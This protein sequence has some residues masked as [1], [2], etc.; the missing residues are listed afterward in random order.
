MLV[1]CGWVDPAT[2]YLSGLTFFYYPGF[3][4]FDQDRKVE[5]ESEYDDDG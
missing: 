1:A 5:V 4:G 3:W 2:L